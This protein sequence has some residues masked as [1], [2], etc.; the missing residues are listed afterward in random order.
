MVMIQG[1]EMKMFLTLLV[2][3]EMTPRALI[4]L[5]G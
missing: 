5:V 1:L 2:V 3:E 4:I